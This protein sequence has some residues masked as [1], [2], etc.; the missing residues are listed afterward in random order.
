MSLFHVSHK[1]DAQ[2]VSLKVFLISFER[3][4]YKG[5]FYSVFMQNKHKKWHT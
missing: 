1:L 5:C 3:L 4:I 2:I